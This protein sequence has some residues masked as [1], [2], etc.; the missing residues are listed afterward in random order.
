MVLRFA[1]ALCSERERLF[2]GP[3]ACDHIPGG[4]GEVKGPKR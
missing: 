1:T 2:F 3:I 4:P